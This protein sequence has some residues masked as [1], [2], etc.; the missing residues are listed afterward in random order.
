M[1]GVRSTCVLLIARDFSRV[2]DVR[3]ILQNR[4]HDVHV[5]SLE[6]SLP[7]ALST[8][9]LVILDASDSL[10]ESLQV[11]RR[12]RLNVL[13][14]LLPILV[15]TDDHAPDTRLASFEAGADTYLLRPFAAEELVSQ[16]K[17]LLRIKETH[18]RLAEKTSEVHRINERLQRA[19]KQIDHELELAKRIQASFLPRTLPELPSLTFAVHYRLCNQVGGDFYDVFRLDEK[20][21]GFYVADAMGHGVPASLLTIFIKKA[22]QAKEVHGNSY[23]L[24]RPDEVLQ[25]LNRELID[26]SL[27]DDP[28][29]TMVYVLFNFAE[30]TV[31]FSRAGHPHPLYIPQ[32]GQLQ[33]WKQEGLLLGV[34]E[35]DFMTRTEKLHPGDKLLLYSDGVDE[36]QFENKEPGMESLLACAEKHRQLSGNAFVN[37]IATD[38]F[39]GRKQPDDLTLLTIEV[40]SVETESQPQA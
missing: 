34:F 18:D 26:Q 33:S 15:L 39:E 6:D 16:V 3:K 28:F 22:V 27:S 4:G 24:L 8:Y 10:Q 11:C 17:A 30:G 13:E 14:S 1:T 21:V 38:L 32:E 5:H 12:L 19:Y 20:H 2:E 25:R 23:K 29:I 37:Q 36:S 40:S 31:Q 9:H 7:E 35:A